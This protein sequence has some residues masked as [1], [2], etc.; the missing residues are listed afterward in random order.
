M[1]SDRIWVT[2][3]TAMHESIS[4]PIATFTLPYVLLAS[5]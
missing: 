1:W 2:R 4:L 3:L 5:Q